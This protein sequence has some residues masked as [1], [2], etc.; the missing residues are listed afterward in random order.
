[1]LLIG[2]I[3]ELPVSPPNCVAQ[4]VRFGLD[5]AHCRD[6]PNAGTLARATPANAAIAR[7]AARHPTLR[8]IFPTRSLCAGS[9][10]RAVAGGDI[11]YFDADHLS[12]SG[13]R[14]L[15][16]RWLDQALA[17]RPLAAPP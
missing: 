7:V 6:V 12:A 4:S 11:L 1:V 15:L 3:P 2:P 13:A 8:V 9:T 16:P 10:C 17:G 5:Q 14:R